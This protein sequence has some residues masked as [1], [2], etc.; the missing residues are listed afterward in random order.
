MN[1]AEMLDSGARIFGFGF[2]TLNFW[3]FC[4]L[5]LMGMSLS[6]MKYMESLL[7]M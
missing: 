2:G 7:I 3:V 5:S 6:K 4:F 1:P